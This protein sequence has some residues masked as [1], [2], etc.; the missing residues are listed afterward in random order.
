MVVP[1]ENDLKKLEAILGS[2]T[3]T[4]LVTSIMAILYER[5]KTELD[6]NQ[7]GII[8]N[9]MLTSRVEDVSQF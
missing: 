3:D 4:N 9:N 7:L 8:L 6:D 2:E 1:S 5:R